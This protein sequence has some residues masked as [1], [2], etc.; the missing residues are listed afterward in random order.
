MNTKSGKVLLVINK[1]SALISTSM[2]SVF[3]DK[4]KK[5]PIDLL[6]PFVS[7]AI[8]AIYQLN[9]IIDIIKVSDY[10]CSEFGF[11]TFYTAV[12]KKSII[13]INKKEIKIGT[14]NQQYIYK[15]TLRFEAINFESKKASIE[16]DIYSLVKDLC[17]CINKSIPDVKKDEEST[18]KLLFSF[19][20]QYGL[21]IINKKES[22]PFL[23][24]KNEKYYFLIAKYVLD[25]E[26]KDSS[27]FKILTNIVKGVMLSKAIYLQIDNSN[28][29]NAK[30]KD[31]ILYLD[32]VVLLT[33]LGLKTNAE[34]VAT[35]ELINSFSKTIK[36]KCFR[37]NLEELKSI[38]RAYKHHL[39]YGKFE[40]QTLEGFKEKNYNLSDVDLFYI[41]LER[42][43]RD[44]NIEI[45]EDDWISK[46]NVDFLE[47]G[48]ESLSTVIKTKM[49]SYEKKSIVLD[50]D[51]VSVLAI[52]SH[53]KN[54]QYLDIENCKALFVTTNNNLSRCVNDYFHYDGVGLV[55]TALD[56]SVIQWLKK[57]IVRANYPKDILVTNAL[58]MTEEIPQTFMAAF[59]DKIEKLKAEEKMTDADAVLIRQNY[60]LQKECMHDTLCNEDNITDEIIEDIVEK[61]RKS[62]ASSAY[63]NMDVYKKQSE[64]DSKAKKVLIEKIKQNSDKY[65]SSAAKK[66]L[67]LANI[68]IYT[69]LG[70][71]LIGMLIGAIKSMDKASVGIFSIIFL[72]LSIFGILDLCIGKLKI[73]KKIV[74]KIYNKVYDIKYDKYIDDYKDVN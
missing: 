26:K 29:F 3:Y 45:D 34:N 2:L 19:L 44:L 31:T 38:I 20:D 35:K 42:K 53:R 62:V 47:E 60:F 15:T 30:F 7:Y 28:L 14:I 61:S 21:N 23:S 55:I 69:L 67:I 58:C 16:D 73:V 64:E 70:L 1:N 66:V 48:K 43:L 52:R 37:H 49:P 71:I 27:N 54:N 32:T 10:I 40:L 63:E 56:L 36:L 25:E 33:L 41:R 68:I 51:I 74:K 65:A 13:R 8:N 12:V 4:K 39:E 17:D 22:N 24:P 59:I 57:G 72:L 9:D 50:N 46:V 5:D 6:V 18:K 11:D